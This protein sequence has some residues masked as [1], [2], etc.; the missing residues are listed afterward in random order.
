MNEAWATV[1]DGGDASRQRDV[2]EQIAAVLAE[3]KSIGSMATMPTASAT[4]LSRPPPPSS[5]L[6]SKM[7]R[8]SARGPSSHL[9]GSKRWAGTATF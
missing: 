7:E 4:L 3:S 6:P 5:Q 2:V 9:L 8:K 1:D